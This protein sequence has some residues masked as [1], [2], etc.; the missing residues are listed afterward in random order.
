MSAFSVT[1]GHRQL[2]ANGE[3]GKMY[4]AVVLGVV[5]HFVWEILTASVK[6]GTDPDFGSWGLI[7][8][9]IGIALIVGL[10]SFVGIYKQLQGAEPSIRFFV[11]VTQGFALD[12][13]TSPLGPASSET[14]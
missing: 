13:L 9:R 14:G 11:A 10:V 3:R 8:A 12:A 6:A 2:V 7:A 5:L 4:F 1:Q